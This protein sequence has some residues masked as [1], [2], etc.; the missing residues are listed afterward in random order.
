MDGAVAYQ[1]LRSKFVMA[2]DAQKLIKQFDLKF[3]YGN[4]STKEAK[5]THKIIDEFIQEHNLT[6]DDLQSHLAEETP[7]PLPDLVAR[8][9]NE[10]EHRT[11]KTVFTHIAFN[12]HPFVTH[13]FAPEEDIELLRLVQ[14]RGFQWKEI[15]QN[16]SKYRNHCRIRFLSLKGEQYRYLSIKQ[17]KELVEHGLPRT[18]YEWAEESKRLCVSKDQLIKKVNRYLRRLEFDRNDEYYSNVVLLLYVLAY[19]YYCAV[20]IN[21][22][23][24]TELINGPSTPYEDANLNTLH[25]NPSQ[26]GSALFADFSKMLELHFDSSVDLDV[27]IDLEDIFWNTIGRELT[28]ECVLLKH[29]FIVL[30]KSFSLDKFSDVKKQLIDFAYKY[31]LNNMRDVLLKRNDPKV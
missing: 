19:N 29:R 24:I 11:Y 26:T 17:V 9:V 25:V 5:L 22:N 14:K 27:Q 28:M 10:I 16:L 6:M 15:A 2:K 8:V 13:K 31:Y 18:D 23:R 21:I 12:Y 3:K 20:S 30:M 4:F 1:Y 7:F